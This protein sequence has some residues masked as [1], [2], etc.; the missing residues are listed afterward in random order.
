[1]ESSFPRAVLVPVLAAA[2]LAAAA[3]DEGSDEVQGGCTYEACLELCLAAHAEDLESCGGICQ[4][5]AYC[6]STGAC[7]CTFHPCDDEACAQ[8]CHANEGLDHGGCGALS[9]NILSCDCW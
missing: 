2:L 1:M 7:G 9:D 3:C 4:V 5:E 8:W 6:L